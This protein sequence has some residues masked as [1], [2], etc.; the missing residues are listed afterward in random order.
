MKEDEEVKIKMNQIICQTC[1]EI[2]KIK[3]NSNW[4]NKTIYITFEC[5]HE[6][7]QQDER[8]ELDFCL[9]CKKDIKKEHK[10]CKESNHKIIKGENKYF[11]CMTHLKKNS[12]YCEECKKTFCDDCE[13][14]HEC[15]KSSY[16]YYF[17]YYQLNEILS[18]FDEVQNN[19]RMFYSIESSNKIIKD[20]ENYYNIYFKLYN[21]GLFDINIIYNI[22]LFYN[23]FKIL[24]NSK[25]V[26][27]GVFSTFEIN[28]IEDNTIFYDPDFKEQFKNLINENEFNFDN[29]TNLFLLSK[30]FTIKQELLKDFLFQIQGL[31]LNRILAYNDINLNILNF[32][33]KFNTY[34]AEIEG[35]RNRI[36]IIENEITN[37]LILIKLSKISIP[38]NLKRKLISI[39]QREIVKKFK[40]YLH[41]IK[42]NNMIINNL[43][44][45]YESFQKINNE[46]FEKYKFEEK[47]IEIENI[48]SNVDS[49]Y[50]DNVYFESEFSYKSLLNTFIYF[51]QKLRYE[52]SNET[53]YSNKNTSKTFSIN[54]LNNDIINH[55]E[56]NGE[57][58][59]NIKSNDNSTNIVNE[60]NN[61]EKKMKEYIKFLNNIKTEFENSYND[62]IIKK[63]VNFE[64]IMDAL[65]NNNFS[66]I[67]EISEN[68][69]QNEFDKLIMNCLNELN[70]IQYEE[71]K[72]N[73]LDDI[74]SSIKSNHF[75]D[76]AKKIYDSLLT[77]RK[78]KHVIGK[79][80]EISKDLYE[81]KDLALFE[82]LEKLLVNIGGFDKTI[83]YD[84]VIKILKNFLNYS[85]QIDELYTD[86]ESYKLYS[87]EN[88]ELD[89]ELKQLQKIKDY[90]ENILDEIKYYNSNYEIKE[91]EKIKNSFEKKVDKYINDSKDINFK[92]V[93]NEIKIFVKGKNVKDILEPLKVI[94][95]DIASNFYVDET[96]NLVAY[97]WCIQNGHELIADL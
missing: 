57:K 3:I 2:K 32:N 15:I 28:N 60:N 97:C 64:H 61:N 4:E 71:N 54:Q 5:G 17:S 1:K 49:S 33:L 78:Y 66:N 6:R 74:Y 93:L 40:G 51:T 16:E 88:C 86:I 36:K 23:Y 43:K 39:L 82:D 47:I 62:V 69:N 96:F 68:K 50:V 92:K 59:A 37:N 21:K 41:K 7:N 75:M 8:E 46:I 77:N 53:H 44:R 73:Y 67:I 87:M 70:S 90:I 95:K 18:S 55:K 38:S 81:V 52:K 11:Y 80:K 63:E 34:K 35:K 94:F 58:M 27:S 14:E 10:E 79:I 72:K 85:Y 65:F 20:F 24:L 30:R 9:N 42:P 19:I 48:E 45:R 25:V 84:I 76:E 83:A 13:C 26:I 89:L 91:I 31:I 22:N 29:V 12:A 56:R